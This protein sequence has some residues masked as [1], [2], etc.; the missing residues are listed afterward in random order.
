MENCQK[1]GKIL[2]SN[3]ELNN[4]TPTMYIKHWAS[5]S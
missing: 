2:K 3:M 1:I 4:E 5:G